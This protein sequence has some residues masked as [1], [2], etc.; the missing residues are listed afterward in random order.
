[1]EIEGMEMETEAV[2]VYGFVNDR[3]YAEELYG[4]MHQPL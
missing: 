4:K 2:G 1:M 3:G